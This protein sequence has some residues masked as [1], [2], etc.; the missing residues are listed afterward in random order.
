M[1]LKLS[2]LVFRQMKKNMKH[3]YLYFFAIIFSVML[4][5]SFATLQYNEAV[6]DQINGGGM[7]SIGFKVANYLLW[8]IVLV[9]VLYA[10]HLFIRRRSKEIGMYQLIGMTKTLVFRLL[11]LENALLFSLAVVLGI[12]GGF[13][14]SRFFALILF[15]VIHADVVLGITFN[16]QAVFNTLVV[17]LILLS[18][19]L[20]QLFIFI[21]RHTLLEMIK[22]D[23]QADETIRKFSILH[24]FLGFVGL[25]LI[26]Y[27]YTASTTMFEGEG[28]L[29][30]R[31]ML[32]VLFSTIIGTFFVFR[33]SVALLINLWRTKKNG[34]VSKTDVVGLLPIMHRM[35]SN[36]KSLTLITVLTA[37]SLGI[38]TLA[39]ISYYSIEKE[40]TNAYPAQYIVTNGEADA[41]TAL[42]DKE[43]IP[44]SRH[45]ITYVERTIDFPALLKDRNDANNISYYILSSS[46]IVKGSQVNISLK[47][48]EAVLY[49]Y[50]GYSTKLVE[51]KKEGEMKV[52]DQDGVNVYVKEINEA[53]LLNG[54]GSTATK[55]ITV[56]SDETY[57][58]LKLGTEERNE[59]HIDLINPKDEQEARSLYHQ[60]GA[61]VYMKLGDSVSYFS[62]KLEY[63][64]EMK[65]MGGLTIFITGF[66]GL[67]FLIAS[68]SILYF[69]QM[70]EAEQEKGSYTILR[71]IGYS[72]NDLLKGVY[73]KQLFNFGIIICVGLLHSY[74]A[75]KSGW[76]FFGT[77]FG[78]PMLTMMALYV[79]IYSLF[80]FLTIQYYKLII[81]SA[82]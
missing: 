69:K 9:F 49:G 36:A 82:L 12:V 39:Y 70:S 21:K 29:L 62:S 80:A 31:R 30:L 79:C 78:V 22:S 37:V 76:W 42:L 4:Y 19:I 26:I 17:F 3:Y 32:L 27:G 23:Q 35:K 14:G 34:H 58:H 65:K 75:V 11:A 20:V 54:Y 67:A 28:D 40:V 50:Y 57:E 10:N 53:P 41:Y 48:N 66:L 73:M 38:N 68:G 56:V 33:Y 51:H 13:L 8:F 59:T 15:K 18:I 63:E 5:F 7:V 74:F 64:E 2:N 45:D 81:K 47:D 60:S 52:G 55:I 46:R 6:L 43:E 77:E 16:L 24:M 71:K 1:V 72:Q 44:Y 61:D 25:A